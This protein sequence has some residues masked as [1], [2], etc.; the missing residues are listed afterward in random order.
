MSA[1]KTVYVFSD[2]H[3]KSGDMIK[4]VSDGRPDAVIHAG[5]YASD[6]RA[7]EQKTGIM[8]YA[9]KG[10]C[11]YF[12]SEQELREISIMGQ[13]ILITHGDRYAA[14]YSYDRLFYLGQEHEVKVVIFGH[15]HE[16]YCEYMD[17]IWLVNPGSISLP[18]GGIP[19]YAEL[20]VGEFGVVPKIKNI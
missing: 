1:S 11:D 10:N 3:G 4:L 20:I 17:G 2:S 19:S 13:K 9:V 14:K 16:A 15:T 6:A 12:D 18:R 8:C 5:D 7:V